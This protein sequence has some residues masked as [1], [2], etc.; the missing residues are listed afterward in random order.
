MNL[1]AMKN[2]L[3]EMAAIL[4]LF[5]CGKDDKDNEWGFSKVYIPQAAIYNGGQS[6]IYPVPMSNNPVTDNYEIDPET[7][8]LRIVSNLIILVL[9]SLSN[10]KKYILFCDSVGDDSFLL[11]L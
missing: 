8:A 11:F 5:S 6:N 9:H 4:C 1:L 7:G 2:V 10:E 3:I